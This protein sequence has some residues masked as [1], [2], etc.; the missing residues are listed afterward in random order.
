[1]G[2][3]NNAPYLPPAT[4]IAHCIPQEGRERERDRRTW[5]WDIQRVIVFIMNETYEYFIRERKGE[6]RRGMGACA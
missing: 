4:S 3:T 2:A 5:A 1:M 6:I